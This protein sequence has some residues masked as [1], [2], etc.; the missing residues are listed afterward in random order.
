MK[1]YEIVNLRTLNVDAVI[2]D[3]ISGLV[4][5]EGRS[6]VTSTDFMARLLG[7]AYVEEKRVVTSLLGTWLIRRQQCTNPV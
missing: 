1:T 3:D 2:Y 4:I 7:V 5:V 6:R